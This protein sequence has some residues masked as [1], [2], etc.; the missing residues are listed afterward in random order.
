MIYDELAEQVRTSRTVLRIGTGT[1]G[2]FYKP[3]R[4]KSNALTQVNRQIRQE[5]LS[6][7]YSHLRVC[8][9]I[10]TDSEAERHETRYWVKQT[11]STA[12]L[13]SVA[14]I[15]F[16]PMSDRSCHVTINHLKSQK[17]VVYV[18][19]WHHYHDVGCTALR[20]YR[21]LAE[22][23]V[24]ELK[25]FENKR[26]GMMKDTMEN[27]IE[28]ICTLSEK[29]RR[30]NGEPRRTAGDPVARASRAEFVSESWN[31]ARWAG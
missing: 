3:S 17:P 2:L 1:R 20:I 12:A 28:M 16:Y 14:A 6:I 29:L 19:C 4:P 21:S 5:S 27:L 9:H 26:R 25:V 18:H 11:A 30:R 23:K 13:E 7:I 31:S 24:R 8:I 22:A 15:M 10:E